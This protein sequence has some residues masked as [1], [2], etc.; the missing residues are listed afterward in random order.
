MLV[1]LNGRPFKLHMI[2][3]WSSSTI[4]SCP[5]FCIS[6]SKVLDG[7]PFSSFAWYTCFKHF[8]LRYIYVYY[9]VIQIKRMVF[10]WLLP[11][12]PSPIHHFIAL[13]RTGVFHF[14]CVCFLVRCAV[15]L[16]RVWFA[17]SS[18][19][20]HSAKIVYEAR[21]TK[22]RAHTIAALSHAVSG[23]GLSV[24]CTCVQ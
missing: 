22:R 23:G 12:S 1:G 8:T 14:A 13:K 2:L 20:I 11:F 17:D 16:E 24:D 21:N 7:N 4:A 6:V 5:Y 9:I 3:T 18:A 15:S 19:N 10:W